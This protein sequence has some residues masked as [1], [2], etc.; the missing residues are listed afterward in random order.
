MEIPAFS[1]T[2]RVISQPAVGFQ[3]IYRLPLSNG[4][5][6]FSSTRQSTSSV[7]AYII[8]TLALHLIVFWWVTWLLNRIPALL[9][10]PLLA[11]IVLGVLLLRQPHDQNK[12]PLVSYAPKQF[13]GIKNGLFLK[14]A[15][16]FRTLFVHKCR[17]RTWRTFD[18]ILP[19]PG[20]AQS[21]HFLNCP[22]TTNI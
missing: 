21:A 18:R 17:W 4:K 22:S 9:K 19:F 2:H 10:I 3:S 20:T 8:Q 11:V 1:I 14:S 5:P 16:T 15:K 7:D 12:L 6:F 13:G